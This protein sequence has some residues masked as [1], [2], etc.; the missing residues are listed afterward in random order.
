MPVRSCV[1]FFCSSFL[2][3][4]DIEGFFLMQTLFMHAQWCSRVLVCVEGFVKFVSGNDRGFCCV[5]VCVCLL[6]KGEGDWWGRQK[7]GILCSTKTSVFCCC[8]IPA[9]PQC[10]YTDNFIIPSLLIWMTTVWCHAGFKNCILKHI[11]KS[12]HWQTG[13]QTV[14]SHTFSVCV[15]GT[16]TAGAWVGSG[17]LTYFSLASLLQYT[18]AGKTRADHFLHTDSN[19]KS[20]Y[21]A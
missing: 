6:G 4:P 21:I 20:H 15:M 14:C 16:P 3:R 9:V 12:E 5:C 11:S 8:L 7:L 10:Q 1:S 2:V 19:P 17:S 13:R 18:A